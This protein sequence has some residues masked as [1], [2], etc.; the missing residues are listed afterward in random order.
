MD[1]GVILGVTST[2]RDGETQDLVTG[3]EKPRVYLDQGSLDF[4][5][6][7]IVQ[8][9]DKTFKRPVGRQRLCDIEPAVIRD[10]QIILQ[11]IQKIGNVDKALAFHDN[12]CAEQGFLRET[13]TTCFCAGQFKVK[14][15]EQLVVE[16]CGTLGGK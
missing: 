6:D 8:I 12:E 5:Q 7:A 16:R 14:R 13:G 4:F 15:A 10:Q 11:I 2:G 9:L 1:E 3:T